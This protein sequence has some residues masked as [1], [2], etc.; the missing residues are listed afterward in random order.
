M[1]KCPNCG[2]KELFVA[3]LVNV[4]LHQDADNFETT[5]EGSDHEWGASSM[6]RCSSCGHSAEAACFDVSEESF[7]PIGAK[8]YSHPGQIS[9][10]DYGQDV[11]S[12]DKVIGEIIGVFPE[13]ENCYSAQF[14]KGVTV[15]LSKEEVAKQFTLI[16]GELFTEG[17]PWIVQVGR[18]GYSSR[19][20]PVNARFAKEAEWRALE[21]C[22][23]FDFSEVGS[24]YDVDN[25]TLIKI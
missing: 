7:L 1:W 2:S 14:P 15:F 9:D 21:K 24:D 6:M 12:G 11:W 5:E 22:G 3:A 23:D 4:R 16:N 20:I 10:T 8:L 25:V 18:T 19:L 17:R 13:Q